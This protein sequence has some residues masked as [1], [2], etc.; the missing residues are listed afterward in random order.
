MKI[1][2]AD[3]PEAN[4]QAIYQRM[5]TERQREATEIRAQGEQAARRIRAEADRTATVIVAE[6]QRRIGA[7]PRRRRGGAERHLRRG[8][9][10]R[11][12]VLRLLPVDA[13]LSA[14]LRRHRHAAGDHARIRSSSAIFND[15]DALAAPPAGPP[16]PPARDAGCRRPRPRRRRRRPATA[17]ARP[18]PR[19]HRRAPAPAS[20]HGERRRRDGAGSRAPDAATGDASRSSERG[21]ARGCVSRRLFALIRYCLWLCRIS[22]AARRRRRRRRRTRRLGPWPHSHF[23]C[24]GRRGCAARVATAVGVA[25]RC[26]GRRRCAKGPESVADVAGAAPRRGGQISTSQTVTGSRGVPVAA[27]AGGLAVPGLLRRVLRPAAATASR[28]ARAGSSRSARAS[29]STPTG[30]IVTNNHVIEGAD[31]ITVN[32]T[33][34]T[35]LK[36]KVGRHATRRPTSPSSRSSRPSR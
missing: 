13:G 25:L 24:A 33:D 36:A 2:R 5:Q 14:G 35:K 16:A 1:R 22:T 3:L 23:A 28:H 12:G 21:M 30:I 6:A 19:R 29:S 27:T 15:S 4:S 34:G 11:S 18:A 31:E 7:D 10:R 17:A 26:R 20:G 8:L 32:F 9:Q